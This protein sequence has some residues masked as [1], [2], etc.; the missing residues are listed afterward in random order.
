MSNTR[1]KA[2]KYNNHRHVFAPRKPP[3]TNNVRIAAQTSTSTS[4]KILYTLCGSRI[5]NIEK[6]GE[7]ISTITQHSSSCGGTVTLTH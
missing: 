2:H 7:Y 5:I 1:N 6:H 3:H 4:T